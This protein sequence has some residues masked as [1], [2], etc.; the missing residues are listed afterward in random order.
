MPNPQQSKAA[1]LAGASGFVGGYLLAALLA[2]Q[3]FS[4]VYAITRRPL[5]REHPRL[6]NRT[7]QFDELA[8]LRGLTCE[9]AFC[10]LGTTMRAAGSEEAFRRVDLDYVLAFAHA[11][12]AAQVQRFIVVSAAGADAQSRNLYLR[13]K[14]EAEQSLALLG[15]QSLHILQPGVLLGWRREPRPFELIARMLMPL[16]HPFLLGA[17]AQYRAIPARTVAHAM[18]G[19]A[20]S[21]RRGLYRYTYSDIVTLAGKAGLAATL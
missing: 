5:T 4:R 6:A 3:D 20:R 12:M 13:T 17:R 11:A 10:C 21:G 7:L 19:A 8:H 18:L 16:A 14:G 2:T 9:A 15:F 1:L